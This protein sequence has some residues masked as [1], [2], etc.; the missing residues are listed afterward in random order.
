MSDSDNNRLYELLPAVYRIRDAEKG[1]PLR[2]LLSIIEEQAEAIRL[3]IDGLY[4]DWFIETCADWVVPYI[5]DMVGNRPLHEI[6]QLRRRDVAKT[7]YYRR[8]KG[9]AAMLEEMARDVTGW[10]AHVVEFFQL[11]GWTQNLNHL[12]R[13]PAEPAEPPSP[14]SVD[15]VGTVN[16]RSRDTLDC[17]DG[18]FDIISHNVDI[19]PIT[20]HEGWYNIRKIGFFL[21]RLNPYLLSNVPPRLLAGHPGFC[22]FSRLGNRAPLFTEPLREAVSHALIGETQVPGPIRPLA[23]ERDLDAY[24]KEPPAEPG[25]SDY[26]GPDR[27]VSIVKDGKKVPPENI[28]GMD[29]CQLGRPPAGR[30]AVD[31]K[32]GLLSFAE[33]EEPSDP[34]DLSKFRVTCTYGF[35]ADMGGGPYERRRDMVEPE[36]E[37]TLIDVA[38]GTAVDTI[39]KALARWSTAGK[40]HCVITVRDNGVYGGNVDIA[41]PEDGWLA[42][43]A[44]NGVWPNIRL[45]GVSSLSVAVGTAT[46]V[47]DGFLIEGAFEMSGGLDITVQHCTIVPG[48]MLKFSGK[49]VYPDRDSLIVG[50]VSEDLAVAIRKSILG[51]IRMP[52]DSRGLSLED[53]IVQA[54]PQGDG[55]LDFAI[56]GNDAGTEPGPPVHVI[57]STIVGAVFVKEMVMASEALFTRRVTVQRQQQDCVR[58]SYVPAGSL[59]PRRYRC[60]P[61]LAL[62]AES[63]RL[64]RDL[65]AA[66]TDLILARLEPQFTS[67]RYGEP[68]YA[69]LGP[70]CAP[71]IRTG[72]EDGAEMGAFCSLKQPQR[73]ANL[74]IRLEEYLPFGLE[75]GFIY[76][77]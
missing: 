41:L 63:E 13:K 16:L 29:L 12:R 3:D 32:N 22:T 9:T 43:Q 24:R 37:V 47:L 27:S 68:A 50:A 5:G 46:L 54:L 42:L 14:L 75:A 51:P 39:Q 59:T 18:P 76:V 25:N 77:T 48:R 71:E 72:A 8:R 28:I 31:V 34:N 49:A 30:I 6:K 61:D 53:S 65:T 58:F 21:W 26:Y 60:Q 19:R 45:V 70:S 17:L 1:E 44:A 64:K 36:T 57:R 33:G 35:S 7:I 11:L 62:E 20:T 38:K 10:G 66:E 74:R 73:E 56:A 67:M 52:A 69:Q 15:C 23:F 4:R 40:P 2:S 55:E